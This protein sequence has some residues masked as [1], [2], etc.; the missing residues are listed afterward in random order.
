MT[1]VCH[2]LRVS[3]ELHEIVRLQALNEFTFCRHY[4]CHPLIEP[5]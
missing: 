1:K 2:D 4:R 3:R 5:L